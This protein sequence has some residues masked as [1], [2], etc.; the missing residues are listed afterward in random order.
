MT[1]AQGLPPPITQRIST[2]K[3]HCDR[4]GGIGPADI[5]ADAEVS[6]VAAH[7]EAGGGAHL[8]VPVADDR[9]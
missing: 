3:T 7:D 2:A 9:L 5:L 4:R 6:T 1:I 8:N